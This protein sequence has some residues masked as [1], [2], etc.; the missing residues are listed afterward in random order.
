[1]K[2]GRN[3]AWLFVYSVPPVS[4]KCCD[5]YQTQWKDREHDGGVCSRQ[6]QVVYMMGRITTYLL[7]IWY[8][9]M[10][11]PSHLACSFHSNSATGSHSL[12]NFNAVD[13]SVAYPGRSCH[14][15]IKLLAR[16]LPQRS[17]PYHRSKKYLHD[18]LKHSRLAVARCEWS[19]RHTV[20]TRR[21]TP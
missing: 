12:H 20:T 3:P 5:P 16:T 8:F 2:S 18:R 14:R 4:E 6:V 15:L 9:R 7:F 1:M 10:K 17:H 21:E 11:T 13:A 19:T